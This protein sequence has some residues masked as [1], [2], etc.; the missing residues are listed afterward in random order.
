MTMLLFTNAAYT[1][2]VPGSYK[3][4][5]LF[6]KEGNE[7]EKLD[8]MASLINHYYK[9]PYDDVKHTRASDDLKIG[10][11]IVVY[12]A[13]HALHHGVRQG[14]LGRDF[15]EMVKQ[16]GSVDNNLYKII[17]NAF[18]DPSFLDKT[19]LLVM[20]SRAGRGSEI[21]FL[22]DPAANNGYTARSIEIFTKEAEKIGLYNTS[23]L[24]EYANAINWYAPRG[25]SNLTRAL[26]TVFRTAHILDLRRL[27]RSE[28]FKMDKLKKEVLDLW[29]G[30]GVIF[31]PTKMSD[32][33]VFDMLWAKSGQYLDATG[34]RNP[35]TSLRYTVKF[36]NLSRDPS[37]LINAIFFPGR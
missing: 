3:S 16:Y 14:A 8:Y 15:I 10:G 12:R 17:D 33:K 27:S 29:R 13:N 35:P 26:N 1:A 23:E 37:L 36:V 4:P 32:E 25:S 11:K 20:V 6:P 34:D 30:W 24:L 31:D 21:G 22:E 28:K 5:G 19:T 9:E 7:K 18:K 2:A